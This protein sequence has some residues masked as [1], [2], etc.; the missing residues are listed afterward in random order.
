MDDEQ[1]TDGAIVSP[2]LM[3]KYYDRRALQGDHDYP[4][5]PHG[6]VT[7]MLRDM[8]T[9]LAGRRVLEIAC[10]SGYWTSFAAAVAEYVT[11]IDVSPN[12]LTLAR[13]RGIPEDRVSF[14][15][16]DAYLL[17][18]VAGTFDAALAMQWFSHVPRAKHDSF[19]RSLHEKLGAGGVVFLGDNQIRPEWPPE[20]RPYPG[21]GTADTYELRRLPDGS[22]YEIIK[23]YFD[24]NELRRIFEPSSAHLQITMGDYWWW[25]HYILA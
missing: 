19:L 24:E 9:V 10:G 14:R 16:A 6:W 20:A 1:I 8:Q 5:K 7:G 25:L 15:L 2:D 22:R 4:A 11:A 21:P 3:R 23:N 18:E 13:R 17:Q 12:M